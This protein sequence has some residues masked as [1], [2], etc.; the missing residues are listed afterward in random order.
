MYYH[1]FTVEFICSRYH[2]IL[3]VE[4]MVH[5]CVPYFTH[6][7]HV[8]SLDTHI[9]AEFVERMCTITRNWELKI[10]TSTEI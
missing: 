6:A 7:V 8:I 1:I 5:I 2:D 3:H 4:V 9:C 10:V